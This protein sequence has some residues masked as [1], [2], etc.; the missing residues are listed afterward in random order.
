MSSQLMLLKTSIDSL[1]SL[2]QE[3][4]GKVENSVI[5]RIDEAIF[6]L[7]LLEREGS[8]QFSSIDLLMLLANALEYLPAV[9]KVIEYLLQDG[10]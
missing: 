6:N 4:H 7:Q 1:K 8:Q 9:Q 2:R 5:E 10:K 3:V